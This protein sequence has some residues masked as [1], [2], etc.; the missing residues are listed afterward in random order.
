MVNKKQETIYITN[1]KTNTNINWNTLAT[2]IG[3]SIK[4]VCT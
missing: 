2:E 4:I 3:G 1:R